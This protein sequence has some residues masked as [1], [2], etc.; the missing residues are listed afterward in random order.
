M[1]DVPNPPPN[2]PPDDPRPPSL[3]PRD[4]GPDPLQRRRLL[5]RITLFGLLD[6][7]ALADLEAHADW[8]EIRRGDVLLREGDSAD[9]FYIVAT[10]RLQAVLEA[11]D[12]TVRVLGV[13]SPGESVGEMAMLTDDRRSA[14]VR[15]VRD[16]LLLRFPS[17]SFAPLTRRFPDLLPNLARLQIARLRSANRA[18]APPSAITTIAVVPLGD[19]VAVGAFTSRLVRALATMEPTLH[20]TTAE[21]ELRLDA[22]GITQLAADHGHEGRLVQWLNDQEGEHRFVVYEADAGPTPW[23]RLAAR[24]ADR[25]L[26]VGRAG[27]DPAVRDAERDL[28]PPGPASSSSRRTLVLLHP[29]G[30]RLPTGTR[31]WLSVRDVEDH[32]H[33]RWDLDEDFAR[34]ARALSGRTIGVVLGGGGARGFAHIGVLA[35]FTE[36]GIPV[37]A[38]G[39]T[40]MGG[41]IAAQYAMGMS[42]QRMAELN[43]RIF[44]EIQ[45]HKGY[46]IPL[47]ALVSTHRSL[48]AAKLAFGDAQIEDL[49]LP[50]FCVSSNL[51]TAEPMVHRHGSLARA[52]LASA[53]LPGIGIPVLHG[54]QLLV[55]GALLN[56]LPT[57]VMRF[58]GAGTVIAVE[59]TVEKDATFTC[60]RVPLVWEVLRARFLKRTGAAVRFPSLMEVLL[61]SSML[62]SAYRERMAIQQADLCLTPPID[63]FS[64]MDFARLEEIADVGYRD[65]QVAVQRWL[66]EGFVPRVSKST[67]A[68]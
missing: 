37:D 41:N 55:D 2:L 4:G 12:R 60:D 24:L 56:N 48:A 51:T 17:D 47:L 68:S 32:Y 22:P 23:T 57:D 26:L 40:S 35:A 65:A 11:A 31:E 67:P 15:A 50:Y 1:P 64:L 58:S 14:T 66:D 46:T 34:L 10:G 9:G 44:V 6:E 43:R 62:H 54:N 38:I 7:P 36:A 18:V 27:D 3:E 19:D 45:P 39:G 16:S 30:H 21:V 63:R 49:W 59:V 29:D 53:S 28:L 33:L 52:T 61:R 42:A 20:L 5:T 13:V 25:I 8:V